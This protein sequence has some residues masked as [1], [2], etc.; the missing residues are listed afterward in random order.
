M[1]IAIFGSEVKREYVPIYQRILN[2]FKNK[3]IDLILHENVKKELVELYGVDVKNVESYNKEITQQVELMLSLGGDGTFLSAISYVIKMKIPVAGINCG[4][5]GFLADIQ[6]EN[7]EVHLQQF[8]NG[9]YDIEERNMLQIIEPEGMFPDFNYAVNELT[10]H[11]LDNSSMI[12]IQTF[13]DGEFLANYWADG[14]I[15]S[16]PTG[17]TAYSLSVG[18]PIVVPDLAG[19]VITPIA[20]HNLTVRPVVVPDDVEIELKINGRGQQYLV[21]F[22]HRSHPLDFSTSLKVRKAPDIVRVVKLHGQSFYSTLR[23]KMMWGADS[24]N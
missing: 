21:S 24:R 4:R 19:L 8:I 23:N 9:E 20:S 11:K 7:V 12:T 13:I 17:S 15:V 5:L 14:L 3:S 16:T 2:F 22:D 6:S 10:V 18:G 1:K